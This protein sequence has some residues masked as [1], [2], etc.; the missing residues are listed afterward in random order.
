MQFRDD[1]DLIIRNCKEY[2]GP[3]S[4]FMEQAKELEVEFNE[5]CSRYLSDDDDY[6]ILEEIPSDHD[7]SEEFEETTRNNDPEQDVEGELDQSL[8][9]IDGEDDEDWIPHPNSDD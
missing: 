1:F 6:S 9:T 8:S 5:L 7:S 2:N 4:D 3:D